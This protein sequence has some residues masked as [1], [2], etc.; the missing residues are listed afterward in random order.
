VDD[1]AVAELH[2][3]HHVCQSPL[4]RDGVFRDPEIPV[5]ENPLDHEAGRLAGMMTPQGL[6][7]ASPEDSLARLGIIT[8]GIVIVNIVFRVCIADCRRVPVRIQDRTDL[9][10]L[11]GLLE[12]P[13]CFHVHLPRGM[14]PGLPVFTTSFSLCLV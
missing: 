9:F 4:V 14:K 5:S 13:F 10:L 12:L 8:N 6:Q 2:N 3:T 1:L 11:H 7:I